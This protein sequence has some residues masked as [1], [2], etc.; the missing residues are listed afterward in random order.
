MKIKGDD[1]DKRLEGVDE[2]RDQIW[3]T[4]EEL[5]NDEVG[6]KEL[7]EALWELDEVIANP[8]LK[9][10]KRNRR[11]RWLKTYTPTPRAGQDPMTFPPYKWLVGWA[12][13]PS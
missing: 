13:T 5:N 7:D 2:A 12:G 3:E 6:L 8:E 11:K 4:L 10:V 9:K 1:R